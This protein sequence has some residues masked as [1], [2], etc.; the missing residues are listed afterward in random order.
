MKIVNENPPNIDQIRE[1]FPL[2]GSEI[3]AWGDTIYNPGGGDVPP[4]L[5]AHEKVHANQQMNDNGHFETKEWWAR[6]LVDRKWRFE[7]ELEAHQVEYR[8]FCR[9]NPQRNMRRVYLKVVARKLSAPL[10]GKM[11]SFDKAK[12]MIKND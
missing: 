10:Y 7:Q 8:E 2:S 9:L 11:V 12:R 1:V 5:V 4:W 6:Y 3:F